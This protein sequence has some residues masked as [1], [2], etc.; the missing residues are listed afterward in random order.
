MK[1]DF[2]TLV[3]R[4][5]TGSE[6]WNEMYEKS[7][8]VGKEVVPFSVADMEFKNAPEIMEGLKK[9]L[10]THIM[11]YTCATDSYYESVIDWM[12]RHHGFTP[13]KEWIVE[14]AGV[15]PALHE[16]VQAFTEP[17]DGVLIMTPVYYPFSMAVRQHDRM[18]VETTLVNENGTYSID[19]ADFEEKA[20]REEVKLL[21][22][23]SPHNPIGRIW[24][25]DELVRIADICLKN[26]VFIISDEIHFDLVLPGYEHVSM[27]TL[28]DNYLNNCAICTAPSKTFNLAGFQTS[29]IL[30][31]NASYRN[32][33]TGARGYFALNILGYQACELAYRYGEDWLAELLQVIDQN[34]KLVEQFFEQKFPQIKVSPLQGTYL[35]WI[36][37]RALGMNG[38]ELETFMQ[39]KAEWF[40]DEGY[41]FGK[42]GEGFERLNLA[43]PT[44]VIKEALER[45]EK[46]LG[47]LG[48]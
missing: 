35:M 41:I 7:P 1:Y 11:G 4:E 43:C 21:I 14:T 40:L 9:Y 42:A 44:W 26:H 38:K 33:M 5:D 39:Q 20:S 13:Q 47:E 32:K 34:K 29:N 22:L 15:V 16:M 28:S 25:R 2:E 23:C 3:R 12:K 8:E 46:A 27:G 48:V 10:D 37:F 6:K 24:T 30:I 36:D 19:F 45:M 18:L 17:G 31:P